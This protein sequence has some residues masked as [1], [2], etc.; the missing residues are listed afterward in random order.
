MGVVFLVLAAAGADQLVPAA[1]PVLF[2]TPVATPESVLVLGETPGAVPV[3]L[4]VRNSGE[5]D[6]RLLGGWTPI[7]ASVETH[8]TRL[9]AGRREMQRLADGIVIPAGGTVVL[10]PGTSHLM[11]G[12]LRQALVQG[13]T[14]PLT[15]HFA[16]AGDV[17]IAVR[18]RRRVDAA[19]ITPFP[20]VIAGDLVL[21]LASAP[22]APVDSSATPS[23]P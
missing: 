1:G 13:E 19:G 22:P 6:D 14:F 2:G 11:L 3:A 17:T 23:G 12:G 21:S 5:M 15:V 20:P 8:Q 16:R 18:V 4:R 7:A 10:E 9:V